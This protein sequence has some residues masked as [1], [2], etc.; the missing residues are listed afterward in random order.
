MSKVKKAPHKLGPVR[1]TETLERIN[2]L[3]EASKYAALQPELIDLS[4]FLGTEAHYLYTH[5]KTKVKPKRILCSKCHIPMTSF[6][7]SD[8]KI[9]PRFIKYTCKM[10]GA[11][12]KIYKEQRTIP[13]EKE[14]I[15]HQIITYDIINKNAVQVKTSES[16]VLDQ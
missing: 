9:G 13:K 3:T 4:Q 11:T 2:F 14:G 15:S 7:S 12:K 5:S 6:L 1:D 10:C 16:H 8:V